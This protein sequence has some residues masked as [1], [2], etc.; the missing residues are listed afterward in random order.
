MIVKN[1]ET[2]LAQCFDSV[3]DIVDEIIVV[4]TGSTDK[5]Q[6][7]C[8]H[9]HVSFYSYPWE[10]DFSKARNYSLSF[11]Q[12][13]WILILD[14]DEMILHS[15]K[16]DFM[17]LLL[18]TT[19]DAFIV[20]IYNYTGLLEEEEYSIHH[21]LRIFRNH[22][23]FCFQGAIHEQV[24]SCE[25]PDQ[26][27]SCEFSPIIIHHYGYLAEVVDQKGKRSR[28]LS[29]LQKQYE[30][31]PGNA[32]VLFNFGNEYAA[33]EQYDLALTFYQQAKQNLKDQAAFTAYLYLRMVL[34]YS[35]LGRNQESLH[36][37]IEA[38]NMFPDFTD[39]IYCTGL[40]YYHMH[41]YTKA[42]S[43]FDQCIQMNPSP[44]N[45]TFIHGS[46]TFL[47]YQCK[48]MIYK[49]LY[50]LES[51]IE[52]LFKAYHYQKDN[53]F[54][55]YELGHLLNQ[56]YQNKDKVVSNLIHIVKKKDSTNLCE[57]IDILVAEQLY[58]HAASILSSLDTNNDYVFFLKGKLMF[59][60]QDFSTAACYFN[61]VLSLSSQKKQ[62]IECLTYLFILG[63]LVNTIELPSIL[64]QL[65]S[66]GN[67]NVYQ[68]YKN[69]Y[70]MQF[71]QEYSYELLMILIDFLEKL[72]KL[73]AYE[74]F[75]TYL[76]LLDQVGCNNA[77]LELGRLYERCGYS[78]LARATYSRSLKEF[79]II[80]MAALDYLAGGL[81]NL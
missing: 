27:L 74:Q 76:I 1:E 33:L 49:Q 61:Q 57:C 60:Q 47:P 69:I 24:V 52:C 46:T 55:L 38:H 53:S 17:T 75:E 2:Y 44:P 54:I 9:Y 15:K 37:A 8:E 30:T 73:Q 50:D 70:D 35:Y 79:N 45:L 67:A 58:T 43:A 65:K 19:L 81:N 28:N 10:D 13:D 32:F 64:N 36:L 78:K 20:T 48:A 62:H 5:T 40:A 41:Q 18:D 11:A 77:L 21:T 14:A 6:E 51:A 3:K 66:K 22:Q 71:H 12:C 63:I 4:D 72:L 56:C 25:H 31:D 23:G 80:D 59:Y 29:L 7:I 26:A 42:L 16:S 34:C 68:V 39:I